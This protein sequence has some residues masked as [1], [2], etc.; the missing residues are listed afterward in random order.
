LGLP[1]RLEGE[2]ITVATPSASDTDSQTVRDS[3]TAYTE[4]ASD[5]TTQVSGTSEMSSDSL[6][7]IEWVSLCIEL[8][9]LFRVLYVLVIV[10]WKCP[11]LIRASYGCV[12]ISKT[13]L[14]SL[15]Y[16]TTTRFLNWREN[17]P[18]ALKVTH[19]AIPLPHVILLQ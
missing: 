3:W 15:S 16:Q 2:E 1:F 17:I 14:Q 19:E 9:P 6:C 18:S 11:L 10:Q 4:A 12:K 5:I 13:S 7:F 8:A